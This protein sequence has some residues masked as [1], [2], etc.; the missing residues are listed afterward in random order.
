MLLVDELV[1]LL[2]DELVG[3]APPTV[4]NLPVIDDDNTSVLISLI[5]SDEIVTVVEPVASASNSH[6]I[7]SA[8]LP[9]P[10]AY[11]ASYKPIILPFTDP[12]FKPA[13]FDAQE[14]TF[15]IVSSKFNVP[16]SE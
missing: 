3:A 13:A 1:G 5:S 9:T 8:L 6:D 16:P 14:F 10:V 15:N 11:D 4:T 2:V 12:P 7:R